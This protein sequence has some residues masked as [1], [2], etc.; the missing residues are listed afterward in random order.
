MLA[1][2]PPPPLLLLRCPQVFLHNDLPRPLRVDLGPKKRDEP[3]TIV[4]VNAEVCLPFPVLHSKAST[5][6]QPPPVMA[7]PVF[8]ALVACAAVTFKNHPGISSK[9]LAVERDLSS[10]N[11]FI[12]SGRFFP[13]FFVLEV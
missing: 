2:Q 3:K 1:R 13:L 12:R 8:V 5:P 9:Y 10:Q 7:V 4:P 6:R 11:A